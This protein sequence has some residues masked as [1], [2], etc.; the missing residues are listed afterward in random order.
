ML[1]KYGVQTI[2]SGIVN[3]RLNT[4]QQSHAFIGPTKRKEDQFQMLERLSASSLLSSVSTVLMAFKT[5]RDRM[6]KVKEGLDKW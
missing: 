2:T 4:I 3:V 1:S 5:A 6:L